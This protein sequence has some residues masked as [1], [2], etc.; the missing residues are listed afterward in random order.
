MGL[1]IE[2]LGVEGFRGFFKGIHKGSFKRIYEGSFKGIY[3]V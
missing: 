2:G 1:G 3:R